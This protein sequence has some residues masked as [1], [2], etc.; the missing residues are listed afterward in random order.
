MLEAL[1][2]EA[3]KLRRHKATWFLV[4]LYPILFTAIF[5]IAIGVGMAGLDPPDAQDLAQWLEDTAVIWG[6]PGN[7]VGRYL[8][9]A[10]VAVVFA[11]EYGWNT[12]KLIVPHRR[13][14]SLVAA[15]YAL[16]FILFAISFILTAAILTGLAFAD[17]LLTGDTVP[18]GLTA[19]ALWKEHG[20]S[21]LSAIGPMLIAIGYASLAAIL[22]RSTIAALVIAIVAT[23]I[24]Q[25]ISNFGPALSVYFPSLVWPLYHA[26]P[27]HHIANLM[28]F[29][30]EGKALAR[31]FPGD[32]IV[33]LDWTTSLA[34][35]VAWLAALY[36]AT[37]AAFSRQDIN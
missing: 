33:D 13:R 25:V 27:G 30:R 15:K 1:S 31:A 29:I 16:V 18:A 19:A 21:A 36:G 17:D 34:V 11:G 22:T 6:V 10:F 32:R 28:E 9:A 3:L 26:L 4:W 35:L 12:W 14:T 37:F 20:E 7:S 2:A 23:T 24:E 8:I 5:L